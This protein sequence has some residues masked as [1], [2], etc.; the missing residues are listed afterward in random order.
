[1]PD[2]LQPI[3]DLPNDPATA[4]PR[5]DASATASGLSGR[6]APQPP[7]ADVARAPV[8]VEQ[9]T[10]KSA[11]PDGPVVPDRSAPPQSGPSRTLGVILYLS[12]GFALV[13]LLGWT[14]QNGARRIHSS[15]SSITDWGD[16]GGLQSGATARG[17]NSSQQA[18][19]E[20][21][22]ERL[23]SGDSTAADQILS[24]SDRWIGE[25]QRTARANQLVNAALNQRDLH[26]REAA[27][28]ATLAL[29][30][31][32]RDAGGLNRLQLSLA[33]RNT[34]AWA[35]WMLGAL[36]NRE[37]EEKQR[38]VQTLRGYLDDPDARTR[39]G[40]VS[41][42]GLVA[43]DETVPMTLERFRNDPSPVVQ[44]SAACSLAEAGMYTHEQRMVAAASFV[45]WMG[46][47]QLSAQQKGWMEHALRDIS[48]LNFGTDAPAWRQWYSGTR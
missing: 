45:G 17:S 22:L 28:Q 31:V 5:A 14:A 41:A 1:L 15:V 36:G 24:E 44:E 13:M 34:R 18:E 20:S 48:G 23:A 2:P 8:E 4:T 30:G 29:D 10:K 27:L 26:L 32:S 42:L 33:D 40:A 19:A 39:S 38:V 7:E 11:P 16:G 21:L 35:L 47:A 37:V 46:D 6:E 43:T 25:T 9:A 12:V 3:R